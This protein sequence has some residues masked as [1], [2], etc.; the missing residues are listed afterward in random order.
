[1]NLKLYRLF[2]LILLV[3]VLVNIFSF[4]SVRLSLKQPEV[5]ILPYRASEKSEVQIYSV[6]NGTIIKNPMIVSF[7]E[8]SKAETL[9]RVYS[10]QEPGEGVGDII[11]AKYFSTIRLK[12]D[13]LLVNWSSDPFDDPK[14]TENNIRAYVYSLVNTLSQIE[15]VKRVQF[16]VR[17]QPMKAKVFGMDLSVPVTPNLAIDTEQSLASEFITS[18]IKNIQKKNYAYVY[19][20][21]STNEKEIHFNEIFEL[22]QSETIHSIMTNPISTNVASVD[23]GFHVTTVHEFAGRTYELH[24]EVLKEPAG[25]KLDFETSPINIKK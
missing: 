16:L 1:M 21:L 13:T 2:T 9:F 4:V 11:K 24:W 6:K 15:P 23:H 25:F 8:S 10:E 22:L 5:T 14:Y 17:N 7:S 3:L 12:H 18:M 19:N 20:H